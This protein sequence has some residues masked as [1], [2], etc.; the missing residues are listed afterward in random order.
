MCNSFRLQKLKHHWYFFIIETV[1]WSHWKQVKRTS[2]RPKEFISMA[3]SNLLLTENLISKSSW[4]RESVLLLSY[5][6]KKTDV[7]NIVGFHS[8]KGLYTPSLPSG[9]GIRKDRCSRWFQQ[10]CWN[11]SLE[12]FHFSMCFSVCTIFISYRN[13]YEMQICQW[14]WVVKASDS[15]HQHIFSTSRPFSALS[16]LHLFGSYSCTVTEEGSQFWW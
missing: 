3:G 16:R 6:A 2:I 13:L 8:L 1:P 10:W 12:H 14:N 9:E 7:C 15:P 4:K 5:Q 11:K